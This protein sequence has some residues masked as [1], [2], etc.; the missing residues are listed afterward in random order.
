MMSP[1][2]LAIPLLP[3]VYTFI[4]VLKKQSVM[5]CSNMSSPPLGGKSLEK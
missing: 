5:I 3:L 4:T 1:G 2:S